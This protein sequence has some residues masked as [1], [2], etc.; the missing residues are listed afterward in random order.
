VANSELAEMVFHDLAGW[1][2]MP[3]ALG[4]LFMLQQ[5]LALLFV[6]E[7]STVAVLAPR[8]QVA[9]PAPAAAVRPRQ[10]APSAV[11]RPA[12]GVPPAK[13]AD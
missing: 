7:D 4:M 2:M 6:T 8:R 1:V 11:I 10:A 9:E 13:R 12:S 5:I 3:M